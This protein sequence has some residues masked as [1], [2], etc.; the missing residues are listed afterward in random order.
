M[1]NKLFVKPLKLSNVLNNN[2]KWKKI[3]VFYLKLII[4][5]TELETVNSFFHKIVKFQNMIF[6]FN[7]AFHLF[8]LRIFLSIFHF[9]EFQSNFLFSIF[10]FLKLFS[11]KGKII[12]FNYFLVRLKIFL[13]FKRCFMCS[14]ILNDYFIHQS[15]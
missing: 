8:K 10:R 4:L 7:F 11:G 13:N 1:S 6:H 9:S 14:L 15:S 5:I 2:P 3:M 12:E